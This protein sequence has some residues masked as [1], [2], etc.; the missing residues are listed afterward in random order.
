MS[1]KSDH[2]SGTHRETSDQISKSLTGSRKLD[3]GGLF[4]KKDPN[5]EEQVQVVEKAVEVKPE[6]KKEEVKKSF[7]ES[8]GET[9][10]KAFGGK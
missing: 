5:A 9:L 2:S 10:E 7:E 1:Y 8:L 4:A 6:A 3:F